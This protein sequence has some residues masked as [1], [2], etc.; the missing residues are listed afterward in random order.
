M[1]SF[2]HGEVLV[3]P[4]LN[5]HD[6]GLCELWKKFRSAPK[7]LRP[8]PPALGGV[9]AIQGVTWLSVH[10]RSSNVVE[11]QENSPCSCWLSW[12]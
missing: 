3:A 5:K 9:L 8:V 10:T 12:L 7:T 4:G 1:D 6:D 2:E 11:E